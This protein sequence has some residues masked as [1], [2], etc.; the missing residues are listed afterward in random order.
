M[1]ISYS[2]YSGEFSN[3][4]RVVI[5]LFLVEITY[6]LITFTIAIIPKLA[7]C[8]KQLDQNTDRGGGGEMK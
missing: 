6:S 7:T 2:H 3:N 1:Y 8:A 5:R 4:E